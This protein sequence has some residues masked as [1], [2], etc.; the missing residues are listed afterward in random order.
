[1]RFFYR[2]RTN[3]TSSEELPE[4]P[5]RRSPSISD[6][7]ALATAISDTTQS[8]APADATGVTTPTATASIPSESA[9]EEKFIKPEPP[10]PNSIMIHVKNEIPAVAV[11]LKSTPA[12]PIIDKPQTTNI[13]VIST[14]RDC[15]KKSVSPT[16]KSPKVKTPRMNDEKLVKPKS[17]KKSKDDV[18]VVA[19]A[20]EKRVENIKLKIEQNSVSII[21][22]STTKELKLKFK[23]ER[24]LKETSRGSNSVMS[25]PKKSSDSSVSERKKGEKRD[26][27]SIKLAKV[28]ENT[29]TKNGEIK[30]EIKSPVESRSPPMELRIEVPSVVAPLLIKKEVID[31]D[32]QQ[33]QFL[34]SFELTPT[35]SL[36]PEKL[37]QIKLTQISPKIPLD[38]MSKS[39]DAILGTKTESENK[40][41]KPDTKLMKPVSPLKREAEK[42]ATKSLLLTTTADRKQL[43]KTS[44]AESLHKLGALSKTSSKNESKTNAKS[45][46]DITSLLTART[47]TENKTIG[48]DIK[49]S[50]AS[51]RKNKEPIKN[52]AK[53]CRSNSPVLLRHSS[54]LETMKKS[55]TPPL[56]KRMYDLKDMDAIARKA[57]T[58]SMTPPVKNV[59][60][61]SCDSKDNI[62]PKPVTITSKTQSSQ[63]LTP[64][65]IDQ[66][67]RTADTEISVNEIPS[68]TQSKF[69]MDSKA[70]ISNI[71]VT[72]KS[73]DKL[74]PKPLVIN[75][76]LKRPSQSD[77]PRPPSTAKVPR[78]N[79]AIS[80]PKKLPNILPKPST[81][82]P[83][84]PPPSLSPIVS[85]LRNPDT[86]IKQ[87]KNDGTNKDIKVYGPAMDK[88]KP[89]KP[90]GSASPAYIPSFPSPPIKQYHVGGVAGGYLNYALMNSHKR[91][92]AEPQGMRSPAYQPQNS[93]SYSPNSPQFSPSYNIPTCPQYKYMKSPAHMGNYFQ[94]PSL[95]KSTKQENRADNKRKTQEQQQQSAFKRPNPKKQEPQATTPVQPEKQK[96]VQSLLDSCNISFP[97]SLSITLHEQNDPAS[98]NPLFNPK[99]N[100][101][102]NNYIEIVKLPDMP[103][104]EDN[105]KAP[106]QQQQQVSPKE[107]N[108]KLSDGANPQQSPKPTSDKQKQHHSDK[109]AATLE[110]TAKERAEKLL[111]DHQ[112]F[113]ET[114]L[115]SI[116]IR[117]EEAKK[118]ASKSQPKA[119]LPKP[120]V[121]GDVAT[122]T[123]SP[124]PLIKFR[125]QSTA[126]K[127][128]S[129]PTNDTG[130]GSN[131]IRSLLNTPGVPTHKKFAGASSASSKSNKISTDCALDLTAPPVLEALAA[132]SA[133]SRISPNNNNDHLK[134]SMEHQANVST[135]MAAYMAR[136]SHNPVGFMIPGL[137]APHPL[138][139]NPMHA[140]FFFDNLQRMTQA[141]TEQLEGVMETFK[142]NLEASKATN[143]KEAAMHPEQSKRH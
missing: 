102:V 50:A 111:H 17:S 91:A 68:T 85:M 1:M 124:S 134:T 118:A 5:L 87:I 101:P 121:L 66:L 80:T 123:K 137:A 141:G 27:A 107:A 36:S 9:I 3:E 93:P 126:T 55:K 41:N 31:I 32:E 105:K 103:A 25:V 35:K 52:V 65:S 138:A 26:I 39:V 113:Q 48:T 89:I 59:E 18:T 54:I 67:K 40:L 29:P 84:P 88:P 6:R 24:E 76:N 64:I 60:G 132:M 56:D 95:P 15:V 83:P 108:A 129:V 75:N 62:S 143:K 21:K 19:G 117:D 11:N 86:E 7:A 14:P 142:S 122:T 130:S 92:T 106:L 58:L 45:I 81:E 96:N 8:E 53:K 131:S 100:S 16:S 136:A 127:P 20:P 120:T 112:T 82:M 46:N 116:R 23:K 133:A 4:V 61:L 128:K 109:K 115:Q 2:V 114:F 73:I 63:H 44:N 49:P 43:T 12:S 79:P 69:Q 74:M 10:T 33:S 38:A 94:G 51:K 47:K 98:T 77:T 30:Y 22:S 97:S 104:I 42:K 72:V 110:M 57:E 99:R 28:L 125:R 140:T 37:Q 139:Y 135:L 34:N 70:D 13:N 78:P 90:A 119:I 71:S